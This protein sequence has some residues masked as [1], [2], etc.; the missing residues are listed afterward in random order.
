MSL[1][2]GGDVTSGRGDTTVFAECRAEDPELA[3]DDID[4]RDL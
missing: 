2:L 1:V 4:G 3:A